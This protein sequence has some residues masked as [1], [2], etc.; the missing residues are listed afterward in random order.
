MT[1]LNLQK[2][3]MITKSSKITLLSIALILIA[4]NQAFANEGA[5]YGSQ[6]MTKQER[7][8][9][10]NKLREAKTPQERDQIRLD[11]HEQMQLRAKKQGISLPDTP[12]NRGGGQGSE[13]WPN[14]GR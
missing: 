12:P 6:L 7:I 8:E 1:D 13:I 11:H 3:K 10:R 5:I 4:S 9:H 2:E 14:R